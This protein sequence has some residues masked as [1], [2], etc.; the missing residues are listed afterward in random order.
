MQAMLRGEPAAR[1]QVIARLA[2]VRRI[3]P[4][5]AHRR[6]GRI[7]DHDL[8]DLAQDTLSRIYERLS[9]F[10]GEAKLETWAFEFC[11]LQL[12]NHWRRRPNEPSLDDLVREPEAPEFV[13]D[14][15]T[16]LRRFLRHLTERE[17]QVVEKRFLGGLKLE[18]IAAA[19]DVSPSTVKTCYYRALTKLRQVISEEEP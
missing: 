17:A 1:D 3:L 10:R 19:L 15:G 4:A 9:T 7:A 5:L 18:E 16:D 2:C 6:G 14:A 13:P 11:R 12:M 8:D